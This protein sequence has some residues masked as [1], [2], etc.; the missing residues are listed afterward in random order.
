MYLF[1]AVS[2]IF[3]FGMVSW[4][5]LIANYLKRNDAVGTFVQSHHTWMIRTFWWTLASFVVG[6]L[7]FLTLVAM[8][9]AVL[10]WFCA[11]IWAAYRLVK[12]FLALNDNLP[13]GAYAIEPAHAM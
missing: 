1:H 7:F 10:I 8:P 12:G 2:L 4:I 13:I 11:W 9:L 5:P 6:Y 3:G